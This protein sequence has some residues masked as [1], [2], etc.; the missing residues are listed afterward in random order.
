[1]S[2]GANTRP[3]DPH[4][5]E[6]TG[7]PLIPFPYVVSNL[8]VARK[9]LSACSRRRIDRGREEKSEGTRWEDGIRKPF[10]ETPNQRRNFNSTAMAAG[11]TGRVRRAGFWLKA[12][13]NPT[14]TSLYPGVLIPR[15]A[16][17]IPRGPRH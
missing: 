2:S 17:L 10:T 14:G 16:D 4:Q 6:H 13:D 8:N 9:A 5:H 7:N 3:I 12:F 1:M 11:S 15:P